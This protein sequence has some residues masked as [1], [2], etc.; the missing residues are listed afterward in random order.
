MNKDNKNIRKYNVI[1]TKNEIKTL[2]KIEVKRI[3]KIIRS[4]IKNETDLHI[5][6][7]F[8]I[9]EMA[10]YM[11]ELGLPKLK[12]KLDEIGDEGL[13]LL[14]IEMINQIINDSIENN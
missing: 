1:L 10:E 14:T 3:D 5:Y 2:V 6:N 4:Q 11:H 13:A 8:L 9:K 12:N 7:S